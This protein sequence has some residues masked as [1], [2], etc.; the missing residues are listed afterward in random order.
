VDLPAK[1]REDANAVLS[2]S[3]KYRSDW[4]YGNA[5]HKANLALGR[6]ALRDGD[7]EQAKHYLIEAG[8]TPGSPQLNSFARICS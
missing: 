7:I 2:A 8:K 3:D 6:V 1:T 4:N 5:V